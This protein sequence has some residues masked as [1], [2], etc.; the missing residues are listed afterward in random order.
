MI[1]TLAHADPIPIPPLSVYPNS[2]YLYNDMAVLV[3]NP[4][5]FKL[6]ALFTA[7]SNY[8]DSGTKSF[9]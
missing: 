6:Q 9:G 2:T 8:H 4:Q 7:P 5:G 1:A 3:F